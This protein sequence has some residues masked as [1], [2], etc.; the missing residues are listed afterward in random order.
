MPK[1]IITFIQKNYFTIAIV[2]VIVVAVLNVI[3]GSLAPARNVSQ[4]GY[5]Q[6]PFGE[7]PSTTINDSGE[8][9]AT[10]ELPTSD[11]QRVILEENSFFSLFPV[12]TGDFTA[13]LLPGDI[14]EPSRVIVI[15]LTD[16]GQIAFSEFADENNMPLGTQVIYET[17]T[18][19]N[20]TETHSDEN[21]YI[22]DQDVD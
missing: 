1:K 14:D 10:N 13:T 2:L 20:E 11:R 9:G 5:V 7:S 22:S 21:P 4:A 15:S 16:Y 12:Q 17:G 3:L 8:A 6:V 18:F 19:I